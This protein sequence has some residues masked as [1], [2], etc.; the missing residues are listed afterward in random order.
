MWG[1][2]QPPS[3][4]QKHSGRKQIVCLEF[5][6][7]WELRQMVESGAGENDCMNGSRQRECLLEIINLFG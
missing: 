5:I 4:L 2:L 6:V 7:F 3:A 1:P